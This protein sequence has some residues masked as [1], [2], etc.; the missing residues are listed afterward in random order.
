MSQYPWRWPCLPV[1]NVIPAANPN[2]IS[3]G[4]SGQQISAAFLAANP[5]RILFG[6]ESRRRFGRQILAAMTH[7]ALVLVT[8]PFWYNNAVGVDALS[9][10]VRKERFEPRRT[11]MR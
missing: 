10:D 9:A 6:N 5:W 3:D 11:F 8:L 7:P 2:H 4:D 1:H